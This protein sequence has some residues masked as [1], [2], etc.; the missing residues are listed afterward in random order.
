MIRGHFAPFT[1]NFL[2][3]QT[4]K[5]DQKGSNYCAITERR[6]SVSGHHLRGT[7]QEPGNVQGP[8]DPRNYVQVS[9]CLN[10]PPKSLSVKATSQLAL[11]GPFCRD[12]QTADLPTAL[13][14]PTQ[15][16]GCNLCTYLIQNWRAVAQNS[17]PRRA[18]FASGLEV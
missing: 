15:L 14:S 3:I 1:L 8:P 7:R 2:S 12:S 11:L 9:F 4:R 18:S 16:P 5:L 6:F 10:F 17:L 13:K